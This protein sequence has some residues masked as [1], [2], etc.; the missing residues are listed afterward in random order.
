RRSSSN[1]IPSSSR[2]SMADDLEAAEEGMDLPPSVRLIRGARRTVHRRWGRLLAGAAAIALVAVLFQAP[3]AVDTEETG[4]LFTFGRLHSEP[5]SPGLHLRIP[6]V[7][8]VTKVSTGHVG[9]IEVF[10]DTS[11]NLSFLSADT[12]LI[13]VSVVVQYRIG[14]LGDYLFSTENPEQLLRLL[15]RAVLVEQMS[16][17]PVDDLLTSAKTTIQARVRQQ[18]QERLDRYG[19]GLL[20]LSVNLQSVEPPTEA[21]GAFREVSDARA[22]AAQAIDRAEGERGRRLRLARGEAE[23]ILATARTDADARLQEARGATRRFLALLESYRA[24]PGQTRTS[25]Y[26]ETLGEVLPRTRMIVLAPGET[27]QIDVNLLETP[28]AVPPAMIAPDRSE[29]EAFEGHH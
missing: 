29:A 1:P 24:S 21:A 22:Q 7:Q 14:A 19:S 18:V 25:L 28:P 3:Y 12:N 16:N 4:A 6:F 20:V 2:P 10:G 15:V 9:R 27:P 8:E 23:Q 26:F 17:A 13:D 11:P 5:V